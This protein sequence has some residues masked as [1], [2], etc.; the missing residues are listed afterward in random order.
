MKALRK[1]LKP[2]PRAGLPPAQPKRHAIAP[3]LSTEALARIY[4]RPFA[5]LDL[6]RNPRRARGLGRSS[7][8]IPGALEKFKPRLLATLLRPGTGALRPAPQPGKFFPPALALVLSKL[9]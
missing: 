3:A 1:H 8:N 5:A 7:A 9:S 2:G 4:A 6:S